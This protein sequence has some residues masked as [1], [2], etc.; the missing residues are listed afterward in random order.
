MSLSEIDINKNFKISNCE[1]FLKKEEIEKY[2]KLNTLNDSYK[3]NITEYLLEDLSLKIHHDSFL[4]YQHKLYHYK[5]SIEEITTIVKSDL[6]TLNTNSTEIILYPEWLLFFIAIVKQKV[7]YIFESNFRNN[8][9]YFKYIA[10]IR[11]KKYIIR[12]I[13]NYI[14]QDEYK[15]ANN[16][17]EPLYD[18]LLNY[19]KSLQLEVSELYDYLDF[20]YKFHDELKENEKYKLMWNLEVYIRETVALL[21]KKGCSVEDI[22]QKAISWSSPNSYLHSIQIYKPLYIQENRDDFQ[23]NLSKINEIFEIEI[24]IEKLMEILLSAK[25]YEDLLFYYLELIK[26]LN[27]N[28]I[29]Q[30]IMGA[31]IK[32]IILGLEEHIGNKFD[33]KK[34]GL[35]E[36]IKKMKV[37]SHKFS[38]LRNKISDK[39]LPNEF[40][41]KFKKIIIEEEDSL[42]KYL[43]LYYHARNYL[44]HKNI[45]MTQFFWGSDGKRT[46]IINVLDAVIIIL[47]RL[48]TMDTE[49]S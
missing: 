44:A 24:N 33:C 45:D 38:D 41:D 29:S 49:S 20:L 48:E 43:M 12:N 19:T 42:E 18:E 6:Y 2:Y 46:I 10:E 7:F 17:Q 21:R 39:A 22:Y 47:Y 14:T 1:V 31:W 30:D 37:G 23:V 3:D 9:Q 26:E 34:K 4:L 13:R 15:N 28:K 5:Y 32:S 25:K 27:A 40:F 8:L 36:C 35:F 11:Y 16:F